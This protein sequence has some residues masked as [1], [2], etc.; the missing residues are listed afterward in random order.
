MTTPGTRHYVP[1][2][3]ATLSAA[4][5]ST[6]LPGAWL[7][8]ADDLSMEIV[9]P[10]AINTAHIVVVGDDEQART[11][12]RASC[13]ALINLSASEP[14][15]IGGLVILADGQRLPGE[16]LSNAAPE[17]DVMVWSH[18]RLG[19]IPVPLDQIARVHLTVDRAIPEE[20]GEADYVQLANGDGVSG[21]IISIGDPIA[22]ETIGEDA[23]IVDV[24]LSR[25]QSISLVH[26]SRPS[27]GTRLWLS[28][29]TIVQASGIVLGEDGYLRFET[30]WSGESDAPP[31]VQWA[32][33]DAVEFNSTRLLPLASLDPSHVDGPKT[34]YTVPPPK[35]QAGFALLGMGE[36]SFQ[37]PMEAHYTLPQGASRF[38]GR[39]ILPPQA[40][41]WGDVTLVVRD[42]GEEVFRTRL[43]AQI[44]TDR[45]NVAL[46][47]SEL[48]IELIDSG[49]GPVQ[50]VIILERAVILTDG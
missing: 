21:I 38:A 18:L 7:L 20:T 33:V 26:Q 41:Q 45:F 8:I 10:V 11:L 19:R 13:L 29:G 48:S 22:M 32:D 47:G 2:I 50:D 49:R 30:P 31:P 6:P 3:I 34:R 5:C 9:S 23:G 39:C 14:R 24:P 35:S 28:D 37:G 25:A 4:L 40:R 44:A 46:S 42:D 1:W 16:L 17:Q 36:V 12:R 43:N 15:S 27:S